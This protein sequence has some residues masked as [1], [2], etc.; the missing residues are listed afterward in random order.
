V[1]SGDGGRWG[2]L[3]D[4]DLAGVL[5]LRWSRC[6]RGREDGPLIDVHAHIT[7]EKTDLF[8][9]P[10]VISQLFIMLV[11]DLLAAFSLVYLALDCVMHRRRSED[12]KGV[13]NG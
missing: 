7:E 4:D 1:E 5:L 10:F 13:A 11:E 2:E 12:L 3:W 8:P 9:C 6:L